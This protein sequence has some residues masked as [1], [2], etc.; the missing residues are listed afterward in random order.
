VHVQS[1]TD[2][3]V[4]GRRQHT[5]SARGGL[6]ASLRGASV[7]FSL[8]TLK[9]PLHWLRKTDFIR[10]IHDASMICKYAGMHAYQNNLARRKEEQNLVKGLAWLTR[11]HEGVLRGWGLAVFS[12]L[13]TTR[14]GENIPKTWSE[15]RSFCFPHPI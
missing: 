8:D 5:K 14:T 12:G 15:L 13:K 4:A 1:D 6:R 9:M 7:A 3:H 10:A 11:I 2:G